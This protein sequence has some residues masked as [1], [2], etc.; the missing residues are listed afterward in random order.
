M[1]SP[2]CLVAYCGPGNELLYNDLFD[3]KA[4][5]VCQ[6]IRQ[7]T[8]SQRVEI[9]IANLISLEGTKKMA[10]KFNERF[11]KLDVLVLNAG[12]IFGQTRELTAEGLEKT[13]AIHLFSPLL[14]AL[15]LLET[16]SK[17]GVPRIIFTSSL[18]HRMA[19]PDLTDIQSKKQY[20]PMI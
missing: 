16:L 20:K 10:L 6:E 15:S 13:M 14:L 4:E 8:G 11:K 19:A 12:A 17:S 3:K 5:A 18:I 7:E 2:F 9:I 1:S